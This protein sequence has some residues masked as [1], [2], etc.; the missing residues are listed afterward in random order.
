VAAHRGISR[1]DQTGGEEFFGKEKSDPVSSEQLSTGL[2][3]LQH[4]GEGTQVAREDCDSVG[5]SNVRLYQ[6]DVFRRLGRF[7]WTMW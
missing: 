1:D 2:G 5:S 3:N 6:P 7:T 4:L